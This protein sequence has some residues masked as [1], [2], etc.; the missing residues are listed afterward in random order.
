LK[1]KLLSKNL[2]L[3]EIS[4]HSS[5]RRTFGNAF[6]TIVTVIRLRPKVLDCFLPES[7]VYGLF[8]KLILGKKVFFVI[9]RRSDLVYRKRFNIFSALD[10]VANSFADAVTVNSR[11][12]LGVYSNADKVQFN[13]LY[14]TENILPQSRG[15]LDFDRTSDP[16]KIITVANFTNLKGL[17]FLLEAYAKLAVNG[18]HFEATLVGSGPLTEQINKYLFHHHLECVRVYTDVSDPEKLLSRSDVFVLPS[19]TEGSSNALAEAMCF[20]LACI[21]T[22]VGGNA[23]LIQDCGILIAPKSSGALYTALARFLANPDLIL[24]HRKQSK[25]KYDILYEKR[26]LDN[27]RFKLYQS[28]FTRLK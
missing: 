23:D 6:S 2:N 1:P 25:A 26:K 8:V 14:L 17:H 16:I 22:D 15:D 28:A 24:N 4:K 21:A 20:G 18:F 12:L 27:V 13:K 9:N 3:I 7:V 5:N 11:T 10:R 19:L